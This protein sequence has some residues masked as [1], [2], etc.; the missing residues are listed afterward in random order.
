MKK[1]IVSVISIII[2]LVFVLMAVFCSWYN[3][4]VNAEYRLHNDFY[5]TEIVT[6]STMIGEKQ[7]ISYDE[8][9]NLPPMD[10]GADT[11][12]AED[13]SATFNNT[14][15]LTIGLIITSILA[16]IGVLGY[17]ARKV[18]R[19]RKVGVTF[20]IITFILAIFIACYFAISL[21]NI[22]AEQEFTANLF[23][24]SQV[25]DMGFWSSINTDEFTASSGPGFAWYLIILAGI[26]SLIS[27]VVVLKTSVVSKIPE[28]GRVVPTKEKK[29]KEIITIMKN[30]KCPSCGKFIWVK[31]IANTRKT[32]IC[33]ECHTKVFC[34]F[35]R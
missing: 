35:P 25:Y 1:G 16:L 8:F 14:Q 10:P 9:K 22:L 27:S 17:V 18:N 19:L 32:V 7:S 20:G 34:Q 6:D 2:G 28:F 3:A 5:L 12:W 4:E 29:S 30:V 33:P 15:Y 13:L 31:G 21:N 11:S 24:E 26:T 23:G